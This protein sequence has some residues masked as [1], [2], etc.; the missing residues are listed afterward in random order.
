MFWR[1]LLQNT[2]VFWRRLLQNM[3]LVIFQNSQISNLFV[4]LLWSFF[5]FSR[6]RSLNLRWFV[7]ARVVHWHFLRG[8]YSVAWRSDASRTWPLRTFSM[9][10]I[11]L[12]GF[13]AFCKTFLARILQCCLAF[14]RF[15]DM[16]FGDVLELNCRWV[17]DG[18]YPGDGFFCD[19]DGG[20]EK[21]GLCF[22]WYVGDFCCDV[23]DALVVYFDVL[24]PS[25]PCTSGNFVTG[26]SDGISYVRWCFL[27][28]CR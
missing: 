15:A 9:D 20:L 3:F 16:C 17:G 25:W 28:C 26:D 13:R 21:L 5:N 19:F 22:W 7:G 1:N 23:G 24:V 14:G 8:F 10:F 6:D 18:L 2:R 4:Q 27:V 11:V 12:F